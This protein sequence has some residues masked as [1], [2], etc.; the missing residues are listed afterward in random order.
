MMHSRRQQGRRNDRLRVFTR[1]SYKHRQRTDPDL[2]TT[3]STKPAAAIVTA[4]EHDESSPR[5]Q[6]TSPDS[7]N[8]RIEVHLQS[9]DPRCSGRQ[10]I[11]SGV[12]LR[13]FAFS[14]TDFVHDGSRFADHRRPS[15]MLSKSIWSQGNA[16][17]TLHRL[18]SALHCTI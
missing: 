11:Y 8:E 14:I 15:S 16:V 2:T 18:G 5:S 4:S 7:A 10:T 3:D 9:T 12:G 6:V 1:T 13:G 17:V